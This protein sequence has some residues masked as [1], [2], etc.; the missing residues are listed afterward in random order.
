MTMRG[1]SR[2][3]SMPGTRAISS[4]LAVAACA[5]TLAACGGDDGGGPI[6]RE[7]GDQLIGQLDQIETLVD[8]GNCAEAQEVAASFAEGVDQLPA[9]VDGELREQL[10]RA[11]GNLESMTQDTDQ[12]TPPT[13]TTGETDVVPPETTE[14]TTTTTEDTTET[15]TTDEEEPPPTDE[16]DGEGNGGGPPE[17][18]PGTGDPG[19]GNEGGGNTGGTGDD[20][21]GGIGSDG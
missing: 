6:P 5:G 18:T 4:A 7:A 12:C 16:G 15:T 1:L 17:E 2:L 19:S 21:S 13:G 20:S 11:S 10:V 9:E 3:A 14:T 8:Q